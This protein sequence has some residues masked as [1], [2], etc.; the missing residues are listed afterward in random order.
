[1]CT[2]CLFSWEGFSQKQNNQWRF[3]SGG[4]IDF[5]N[6]P[7]VFIPGSAINTFEGSASV[8][9]KST[10]ALLFYTDGVTVWN[11]QNQI[12]PNG[13]GLL[14]GVPV[15]LS[16]TTAAVIIPKPGVSY[17]YYVVTIDEQSANNGIRYS[18]VDMNLNGGLGDIIPGFK[19]I[20]VY[21]TT[22]EKL[23]V[24][25]AADQQ[26]YW[27]ISHDLPGNS[28]LA[29]R[30]NGFGIE[31]TPVVSSFGG[32]Q[33]NGSGHLKI[34]RQFNR[35]A[36]GN[37]F[38]RKV[39]LF[40]FDNATGIVTNPVILNFNA[41]NPSIYGVEFSPNG[42]F[43]YISNL[44]FVTQYN[45]SLSTTAEIENSRYV[46]PSSGFNQPASLQLGPDNKI[47]INSGSVDAIDC[48]NQPGASC[49]YR[50][51]AILNQTGGGG[52]GL[53]KWVY[54]F[55]DT[56]QLAVN[57]IISNDTCRE[58]PIAFSIQSNETVT[59][60][61]WNF[62]DPN[63]GTNNTSSANNPSHLFSASGNYQ[64]T[65]IVSLACGADTLVFPIRV[66]DC[67]APC[68]GVINATADS[69]LQTTFQ[70]SV[71]T[72]LTINSV[73]WNFSDPNSGTNNS[74][75]LPTPNHIFS[76]PGIYTVTAIVNF[77]CGI[78][79]LF[80]TV[81]IVSCV[82]PPFLEIR[83]TPDT[84]VQKPISFSI[85]AN[86][87]IESFIEWDFGDPS[88]G[89]NNTSTLTTP[90]H[91][92]TNPGRY[93]IQCILQI[94]CSPPPDPNNPITT[95]C[96][97]IDTVYRTISFY[98]CDSVAPSECLVAIPTAF[99]PNG[100]GLNEVF[101]P[102]ANCPLESYELQIYSRWG[103][104]IFYSRRPE[105]GWDGTFSNKKCPMGTYVYTLKY[106]FS[107][108]EVRFEKGAIMLFQ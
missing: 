43:L 40:D 48:P 59:G 46:L 5:N 103:E 38:D 57:S 65:A 88:S 3:G 68:T 26:S 18:V 101:R 71:S 34:N 37:L 90:T 80:K 49:G 85:N 82:P 54:Y 12:M 16:S 29:F 63:S 66:V 7:P 70:F 79:T 17:E 64:V 11:A 10:G 25:P 27:L 41:S 19:N 61:S 58:A 98:D 74:S 86:R 22:S 108:Q 102:K 100:D 106:K 83:F 78:D 52:Y 107:T 44:Q 62:G 13:N 84:C 55:S 67:A 97:Y 14:G 92:F 72:N 87:P 28:F 51:N 105:F 42:E 45:I 94:N 15:S 91:T 23:E 31:T 50:P 77:N 30:V 21:Q 75:S 96:F 104:R 56:A 2:C 24:V 99:T 76:A 89:V 36:M 60:V 1:M 32:V 95:P 47:Y 93:T 9:D 39:E 33:G 69:C 53:P 4:G 35:L 8:A 81:K 20:P 6:T 73:S